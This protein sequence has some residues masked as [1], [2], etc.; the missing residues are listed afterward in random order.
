MKKTNFWI[1]T[2]FGLMCLATVVFD[3][4]SLDK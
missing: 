4:K 2:L 1:W 3:V